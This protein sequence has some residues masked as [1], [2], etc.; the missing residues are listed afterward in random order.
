MKAWPLWCA[1]FIGTALLV[2]IG[3]SIV[4]LN[5]GASSPL[6]LI[7]PD[8]GTRRALTGLLFGA[9]G[10]LIAVSP[11]GMI[12]G[13][14]I[15]PVVTLAFW[16]ER[17]IR[18]RVVLGYVIA[19][20]AG[21]VIGA[22]PL[23][24]WG[25]MG[26]SV[27]YAA[28]LPGPSG[29][30]MALLGEFGATFCLIAGLLL[31]LGH[32]RL[33]AYTPALFPLLYALLVWLEAPLSG[34]STNPARSLGPGLVAGALRGTWIDW[35]GPIAGT[36]AAV[37]LRRLLPAART[38]EIRVAKVFHFGHDRYGVFA[39]RRWESGRPA[40]EPFNDRSVRKSGS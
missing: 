35:L 5:F 40:G 2:G 16:L 32:R 27:S 24:W 9:V 34:T 23:R 31:F 7:L 6:A 19:Q 36:L 22:L 4:I 38:L 37:G 10:A 33:R 26:A 20:L 11:V 14:H 13:A 39:E 29:V 18:G 3:C 17:R 15:N 28:T 21:G 8:E 1:E 30:W 25:A 12:S